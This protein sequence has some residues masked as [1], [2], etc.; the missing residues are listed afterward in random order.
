MR[1]LLAALTTLMLFAAAPVVA[2]DYEDGQAAY[3]AGDYQKAFRLWEPLAEK[4]HKYAQVQFGWLYLKGE[5]I[6]KNYVKAVYWYRKAAEQGDA[7]AQGNL[8][9]MYY[10][11]EGE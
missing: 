9:L 10:R 7:D 5:G 8:G 1:T 2:G 11:G 4:G 3:E 6:P